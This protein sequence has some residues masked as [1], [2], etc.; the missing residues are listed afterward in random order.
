M[1]CVSLSSAYFEAAAGPFVLRQCSPQS[2]PI[3]PRKTNSNSRL[4]T[5]SGAP[6]GLKI[7]ADDLSGVSYA[8]RASR[9]FIAPTKMNLAPES[10]LNHIASHQARQTAGKKQGSVHIK[11]TKR[12][13]S[14][15]T[16]EPRSSF[17]SF[18][19]VVRHLPVSITAYH[20]Q[21]PPSRTCP[22]VICATFLYGE[23]KTRESPARGAR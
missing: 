22:R 5:V 11:T 21:S 8:R 4:Y 20:G 7:C 19:G 23:K 15:G 14:D 16:G 2:V 6:S 9:L 1:L 17:A 3:P 18:E 10:R 13:R 12:G